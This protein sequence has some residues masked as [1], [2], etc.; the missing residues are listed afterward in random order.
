MASSSSSSSPTSSLYTSFNQDSSHFAVGLRD[1]FRVY[2]TDP[3]RE[4]MRRDFQDGGIGTIEMLERTNWIALV[5]GGREPKYPQN[6]VAFL[7]IISSINVGLIQVVM[8]DDVQKGP[9]FEMEFKSQVLS[10]RLR[11]DLFVLLHCFGLT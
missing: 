5:G 8:W 6:K 10:V 3:L 11:R 2:T 7:S 1:G 9:A 4:R